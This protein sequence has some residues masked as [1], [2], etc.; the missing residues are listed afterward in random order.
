MAILYEDDMQTVCE[1]NWL[2][3]KS[4]YTI[5]KCDVIRKQ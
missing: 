2:F 1:N 5:I 3:V 4:V